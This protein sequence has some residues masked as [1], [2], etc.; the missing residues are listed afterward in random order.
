MWDSGCSSGERQSNC[1]CP[2]WVQNRP[3]GDQLELEAEGDEAAVE[4]LIAKVRIGPAAA[5]VRDIQLEPRELKA[6]EQERFIVR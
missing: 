5:R 1:N 4:A 3:E 2:V 6:S